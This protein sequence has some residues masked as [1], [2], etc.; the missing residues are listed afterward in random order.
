MSHGINGN[1][2]GNG[3]SGLLQQVKKKA[4]PSQPAVPPSESKETQV[5]FQTAEGTAFQT[6]PVRMT[7]HVVV[8]ELYNPALVPRF[9]EV[10]DKFKITLKGQIVY[11]GRAVVSKILDLGA[12]VVCEAMLDEAHWHARFRPPPRKE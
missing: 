7:H 6:A 8:F 10:L 3:K 2:N 4:A 1:G 12:K 9:S 11:S 5:T